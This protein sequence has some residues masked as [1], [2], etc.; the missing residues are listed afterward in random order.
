MSEQPQELTNFDLFVIAL[1]I[2]SLVNIIWY[3]APLSEQINS[4]VLIVDVVFSLAFLVDFFLRLHRAPSRSSYFFHQQGWLELLSSLPF[5]YIRILRIVR[6]V[7]IYRPLRTLGPRG[8]WKRLTVDL[9]G[10]ALLVA[11]F[12]TIVVIQY[13]SMGVL[14]AEGK[15]PDANIRTASDAVWWSYV[16][17]TTVGYG[18]RYPVTDAGRLVGVALLTVGVGLFGVL[19]GFLANTFLKPRRAEPEAPQRAALDDRLRHLETLIESRLPAVTSQS[20][21]AEGEAAPRDAPAP[22]EAMR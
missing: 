3:I 20:P 4:V 16:T 22:D 21:T 9:A 13:A 17:A 6:L 11:L 1:S 15:N 10:S 18:D 8:I 19:T 2:F 12:L 14:W 7:R 5:P